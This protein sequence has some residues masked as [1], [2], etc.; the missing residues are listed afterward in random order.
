VNADEQEL[1]LF[2]AA[3]RHLANNTA[4]DIGYSRHA[5]LVRI[6]QAM[7]ARLTAAQRRRLINQQAAATGRAMASANKDPDNE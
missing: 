6:V 3:R 7:E 4:K 2:Q 1:A 5:K